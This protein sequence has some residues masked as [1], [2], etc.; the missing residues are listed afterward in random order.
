MGDAPQVD[1]VSGFSRTDAGLSLVEAT[2]VLAVASVLT[3]VLAPAVRN[4]VQTS[5][6]SAAKKDVEAIGAALHQML[7]D[8][9][10][11]WFLQDGNGASATAAPLHST[12]VDL[13]V[14]E[15]RIPG[16]Y[17]ARASGTDWDTAVNN[18]T[19]Q[20]L[21]Y[22]L[23]ANTPS[24]TSANA[25]RSAANMSVAAQFDPDD[26]AQYNSEHAWRGP[27][28]AGP[29]GADPWGFRYAANVEFLARTLNTTPS[30]SVYD[31]VVISP[32]DNGLIDTAFETDGV[33]SGN[34]VF[35]VLSG[36][37]R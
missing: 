13:L 4:F 2:V 7:A 17:T 23:V 19:V 26:G 21:D 10:E 30:G 18:T 24:N 15:G 29:I 28:L 34:D 20:R 33:T 25:Y 22:Y 5:Q 6:Q 35:Y 8:V 16:K 32:G 9:G 27:Y 31:V 11:A 1:V 12:K 36:G 14:S 3:A 37:T